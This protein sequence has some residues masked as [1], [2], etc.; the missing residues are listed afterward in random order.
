MRARD[1][2]V[3]LA[4]IVGSSLVFIDGSVVALAL[5]EIQRE[6][7]TS[8]GNVAWI[9][10]LYT[11]VLGSLMLLGGA[12]ADRYG[13][14]RIF[15]LGA[16]LFACSSIGCA[17]A[18]S[19]PSMLVARTIQ[20]LG[21]M[22]LAPASLAIL[23]DHFSG[24]ARG[25][26]IAAWSAFSAL[27]STLGPALGGAL[28]DTFGWRSVFWI[29]VPLAALV[30][31]SSLRHVSESRNPDAPRELDLLG[32]LLGTLGL[33]GITFALIVASSS[34]WRNPSVDAAAAGGVALLGLFLVRERRARAP[35]VPPAIFSSR[36]FGAIN[37]ATLFLYGALGGLFYE[38]PFAMIQA[39]HYTALQTA[40]ATLPMPLAL[41]VLSRAGA[42]LARRFG[43]RLVLTI[44]PSVVAAGF[45]LLA[46][47]EP[48]QGY[49]VGFLPGLLG[50]G[51]G[52]GIT[53]APLTT[54][55]IGA[56]DAGDVGIASGINNAVSRIAGLLAIAAL[57]VLLA[58]LYDR[59][60]NRSL[61]ALHATAHQRLAAAAQSDRLGGAHF[62]D[63]AIARASIHAFESGF[64]GVAF[65]CALLAALAAAVDAL[66]IDEAK[67]R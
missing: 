24:D 8:A 41:V 22:L 51:L 31:V 59:S 66:G 39:H 19:I 52:M 26:A 44:G 23:G 48:R 17:F 32:A 58:A 42:M 1:T 63:P 21:G 2:W 13:R 9:V 15:I 12:L 18:W 27:T 10:E 16:A 54:T 14:K 61:D 47:L 49:V 28:I 7:H 38:L 30:V 67:L 34:G 36:T 60:M 37:L 50:V 65:A 25:R 3:L 5:P 64:R 56:A 55:M 43:P 46:L 29:T 57:T 33:G 40:F 45:A 35:L 53:V 4:T 62:S 20:G 6:F 11:L